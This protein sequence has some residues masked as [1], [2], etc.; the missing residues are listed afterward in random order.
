MAGAELILPKAIGHESARAAMLVFLAPKRTILSRKTASRGNK[1]MNNQ[2]DTMAR[3]QATVS[4]DFSLAGCSS[5]H[6]RIVLTCMNRIFIFGPLGF[7]AG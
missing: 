1:T 5:G 4:K 7:V 3:P 2:K 6:R